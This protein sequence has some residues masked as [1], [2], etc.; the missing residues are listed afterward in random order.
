MNCKYDGYRI[1]WVCSLTVLQGQSNRCQKEQEKAML[2][3]VRAVRYKSLASYQDQKQIVEASVKSRTQGQLMT[4][5]NLLTTNLIFVARGRYLARGQPDCKSVFDLS[6][7]VARE[8]P[9]PYVIRWRIRLEH[10]AC[11]PKTD[12]CGKLS[13]HVYADQ[14][15]DQL[16]TVL[17]CVANPREG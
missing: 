16:V 15:E 10:S 6:F 5:N 4:L 11:R 14:I 3:T 8:M 9:F 13:S 2:S 7:I 1:Y 12:T 17:Y